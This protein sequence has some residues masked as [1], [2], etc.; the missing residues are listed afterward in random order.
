MVK[1]LASSIPVAAVALEELY[2]VILQANLCCIE[3]HL[4][5]FTVSILFCLNT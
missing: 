2:E 1:Q 4:V 3:M 5:G